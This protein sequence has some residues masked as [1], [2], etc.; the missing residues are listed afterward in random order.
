MADQDGHSIIL[1]AECR[2]MNEAFGGNTIPETY[3]RLILNSSFL[4]QN[5]SK[6]SHYYT[7]PISVVNLFR[8]TF[9]EYRFQYC[10]KW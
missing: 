6:A 9:P 8:P 4:I 3:F 1:N 7:A 5:C 10:G 2:I